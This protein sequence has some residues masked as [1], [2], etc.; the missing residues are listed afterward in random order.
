L[1]ALIVSWPNRPWLNVLVAMAFLFSLFWDYFPPSKL[2][3][4]ISIAVVSLWLAT[5]VGR[6]LIYLAE[7]R[8]RRS[9]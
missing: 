3:S 6:L 7:I 4:P 2:A 8:R 5:G 1:Q 9:R